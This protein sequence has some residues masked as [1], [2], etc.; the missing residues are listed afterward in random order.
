MIDRRSS[1]T[2]IVLSNGPKIKKME[3]NMRRTILNKFVNTAK[4]AALAVILA[5]SFAPMQAAAEQIVARMSG[6][7]SPKH[8]SSIMPKCLRMK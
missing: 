1:C 5:V 2:A 7:W 3:E 4:P 8:Q 6:H